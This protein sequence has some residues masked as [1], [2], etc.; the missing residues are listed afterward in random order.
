MSKKQTRTRGNGTQPRKSGEARYWK[1]A[2]ILAVLICIALIVRMAMLPT[3]SQTTEVTDAASTAPYGGLAQTK[4]QL[5]A[6]VFECACGQC[7]NTALID[8]SCDRPHGALE[9]KNL[10]RRKLNEGLS[11]ES[12][13]QLIDRKYGHRIG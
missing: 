1:I 2:A 8:C 9:E 11:V 3:P 6:S 7:G 4:V 13:I 5:V 12:V 10:I